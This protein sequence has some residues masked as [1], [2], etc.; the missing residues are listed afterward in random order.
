MEKDQQID[1]ILR[2]IEDRKNA[3]SIVNE[4][5]KSE[6]LSDQLTAEA[7]KKREEQV[8]GFS[9]DLN[10]DDL[11]A[12]VPED[13]EP[14]PIVSETPAISQSPIEQEKPKEQKPRKK[15]KSLG[16]LLYMLFVVLL[17]ALIACGGIVY[18]M[19]A[20]GI[21]GSDVV[22]D[23]EIP[24]GA[25]TQ[26]IAEI[27]EENGLIDNAFLFRIY[28]KLTKADGLWQVGTFM[29]SADMGYAGIVEE[30]QT[31]T[32][33]ENVNVT[34]PEGYTVEEIARVLKE[35]GVCEEEDFYNAVVNGEFDYDFVKAIPTAADGEEYAGRI[36]RL[37]GYLFPDT[38]NF[39]VGSSG[40]MVVERMLSN[41]NNK[42]TPA[43]RQ[44]IADKGWTIDEAI[45]F[46]SIIQGE[47]GL[48]E[49]M[50]AVS[51]VLTNRM[52]PNSGYA[53]LECC[54]TRD[55]VNAIL[56]S[57]S[58]VQVTTSA[59]NT[60]IR[61]GLPVGAINNPGML[62][63]TSALNPSDDPKYEKCYFFAT[64]YDTGI[65]YFSNTFSQHVAICR[66]YGIGMYG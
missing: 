57:L 23:V 1:D 64:D 37:E 53:K 4:Q 41:F 61:E 56:P 44:Q 60:Y 31:S 6:E 51:R 10:V 43:I 58:G 52:Q 14:T 17:S 50:V 32:P 26:Q 33:R 59:Y 16:R 2:D 13:A 12:D 24:S 27:L 34:I 19:D 25:Y 65:T 35:K 62:A 5:T 46:A 45:T 15:N 55:Y 8:K 40:E 36:Y 18:F 22:V 66:R 11:I 47:A 3:D 7:Q 49:D 63:I 42:L 48:P 54:S 30:L 29:L 38:Y 9:L 21:G 39:Y 28:A 20:S